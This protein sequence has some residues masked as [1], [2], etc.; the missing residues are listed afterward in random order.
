MPAPGG[1]NTLV[2]ALSRLNAA[3]IE[4]TDI[5]LRRPSLDDVFL[6]L[7][8]D[9]TVHRRSQGI[10]RLSR[11]AAR[12]SSQTI[13]RRTSRTTPTPSAPNWWRSRS[14]VAAH[15]RTLVVVAG[16]ARLR[17]TAVSL[18]VLKKDSAPDGSA[19]RRCPPS[20]RLHHARIGAVRPPRRRPRRHRRPVAVPTQAPSRRAPLPAR[21]QSPAQVRSKVR[22]SQRRTRRVTS[23][24][25]AVS[26]SQAPTRLAA[27][28]QSQAC[29]LPLGRA[30]WARWATCAVGTSRGATTA[31][32]AGSASSRS[33]PPSKWLAMSTDVLTAELSIPQ[34]RNSHCRRRPKASTSAS[35]G[36]SPAGWSHRPAQRRSTHRRRRMWWCSPRGGTY[37]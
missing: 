11:Q 28:K 3:N 22:L 9:N 31:T 36:C 6:S 23:P 2:E 14:W 19:T 18:F 35:G 10:E 25:V 12:A 13:N 21:A 4:L 5:A 16:P 30:T 26:P 24:A 7:T 29:K 8:S 34:G 32:T 20:F 33:E 27:L 15:A 37:R 1:P 17:V